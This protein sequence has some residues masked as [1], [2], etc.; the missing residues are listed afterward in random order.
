MNFPEFSERCPRCH[1]A[2]REFPE[3]RGADSRTTPERDIT[4]CGRCGQDEAVRQRGGETLKK[5][6]EWPVREPRKTLRDLATS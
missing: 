4:I 1:G 2:L 5:V 3:D 6:A